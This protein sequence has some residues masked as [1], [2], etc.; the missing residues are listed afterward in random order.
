VLSYYDVLGVEPTA[1]VDAIRRAWRIKVRL[2]HPD[3]HPGAP[4]DV[5]AEA[6]KETLR[7][8]RAWETLGEPTRRRRYD[9]SL[10]RHRDDAHG[11][12]RPAGRSPG[13]RADPD[14]VPV[15]CSVCTT[16]QRV[17]RMDG[18]FD[19]AKCNTAWAFAKCEGCHGILQ[20]AEHRR[21]WRC[22]R[23]GRH[24]T[25]SWGGGPR[26]VFCVRCKAPTAVAAGLARFTCARCG[27]DHFCCGGC[28]EFST[29]EA[30][31]W[32]RWRCGKCRR[33]NRLS[34]DRSLDRA[35]QF[36]FWFSGAC[37]VGLGLLLFARML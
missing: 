26:Y 7:I 31:P 22:E 33:N 36:S 5:L 8:N 23:C 4:D 30:I 12:T 13:A 21:T 34:S 16:A 10:A 18:R 28:G 2:M 19:C 27:L 25:A 14:L 20:V 29:F 24:Q 9:L 37:C 1:D 15:V 6:A 11:R 32:W 35:Q 3:K 17:Q